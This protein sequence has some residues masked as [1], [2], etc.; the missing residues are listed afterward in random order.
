M[1]EGK[2]GEAIEVQKHRRCRQD[3]EGLGALITSRLEARRKF[4]R[5]TKGE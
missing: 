2:I 4:G 3:D 5:L 1:L